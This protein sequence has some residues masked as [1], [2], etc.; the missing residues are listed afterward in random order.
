MYALLSDSFWWISVVIVGLAI[1]L[2]SSYAKPLIDAGFGAASKKWKS[3]NDAKKAKEQEVI[4]QLSK[5]EYERSRLVQ[6]AN[7]AQIRA[8]SFQMTAVMGMYMTITAGVELGLIFLASAV[9]TITCL[10]LALSQ[11]MSAQKQ[12]GYADEGDKLAKNSSVV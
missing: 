3:S 12:K 5:S 9:F 11:L 6:S 10:V 7:Y 1:N 8:L 4:H 2:V